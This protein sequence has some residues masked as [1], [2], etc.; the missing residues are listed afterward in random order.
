MQDLRCLVRL[1]A[2]IRLLEEILM[3]RVEALVLMEEREAKEAEQVEMA[4]V[5]VVS[6]VVLQRM[7]LFL[8]VEVEVLIQGLVDSVRT[9]RYRWSFF[10]DLLLHPLQ[11][12]HPQLHL[13]VLLH[14]G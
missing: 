5:T 8:E 2:L 4:E 6:I 1:E 14:F 13:L 11:M 7:E 10:R 3:H 12:F 9:V